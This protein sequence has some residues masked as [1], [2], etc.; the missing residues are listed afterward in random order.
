MKRVF[1][2]GSHPGL[3]VAEILSVLQL[4][5][6]A[7]YLSTPEILVVDD[8]SE[9]KDADWLMARLGGTIRLGRLLEIEPEP[10]R[11]AEYV[12]GSG[13]PRPRFGLSLY[14]LGEPPGKNKRHELQRQ[15]I[16]TG[17]ETKRHLKEAGVPSRFVRPQ[18][19]LSLSSVAIA[20]NRLL[21]DGAD[22]LVLYGPDR[23]YLAATE[24]IQPFEEFAQTDYGRPARDTKQ[25]ML[26]PKLA[27]L[28][29]NLSGF[30]PESLV[31]DPFCGSGTVLTEAARMGLKRGYA[32]DLNPQAIADSQQNLTWIKERYP[33]I[34]DADITIAVGDA[35][36]PL[37]ELKENGLDAI[38]SE[39]FLGEP[40]SGR[41]SRGE[42]ATRLNEITLLIEQATSAW[43]HVLKPGGL[44]TLALPAY[45]YEK[46]RL[47]TDPQLP[48]GFRWQPLLSAELAERLGAAQ[49]ERGGLLYGRPNQLVW[50]EIVRIVKE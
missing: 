48:K 10:E 33:D 17:M 45:I 28:M 2:L 7:V 37:G 46:D 1:V 47:L 19:G 4:E 27:R 23:S 35:R 34:A 43:R 39:L 15:L 11:I 13:H 38:V 40:R 30:A 22:L 16:R 42:L 5:E 31:W 25:G 50:R 12:K 26:P 3:S 21:T 32:S 6:W 29:L 18:E 49:T 14:A 44:A 41:E 8:P 20:K 9:D 24:A 36:E